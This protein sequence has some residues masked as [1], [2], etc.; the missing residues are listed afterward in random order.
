MAGVINQHSIGFSTIRSDF[1]DQEQ[2]V[3]LIKEV[4]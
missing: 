1:R 3:R 4:I 2:K